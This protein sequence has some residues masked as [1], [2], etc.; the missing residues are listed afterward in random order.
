MNSICEDYVKKARV[1]YSPRTLAVD[2]VASAGN[3]PLDLAGPQFSTDFSHVPIEVKDQHRKLK[4]SID[5]ERINATDRG[6]P[7]ALQASTQN[8]FDSVMSNS[9]RPTTQSRVAQ[10]QKMTLDIGSEAGTRRRPTGQFYN[11]R[12]S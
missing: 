9:I 1:Q 5:S 3:Q 7:S 12:Y 8:D 10:G 11:K 6:R 2:S 4:G